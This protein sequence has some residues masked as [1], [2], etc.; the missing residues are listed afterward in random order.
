M[1]ACAQTEGIWRFVRGMA[2]AQ[3]LAGYYSKVHIGAAH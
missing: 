2:L 1:I 3:F